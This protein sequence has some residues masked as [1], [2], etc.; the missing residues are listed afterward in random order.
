M[1][2][3]CTHNLNYHSVIAAIVTISDPYRAAAEASVG[4]DSLI[5][6]SDVFE[7]LQFIRDVR[8]KSMLRR[9]GCVLV[10]KI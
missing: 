8:C 5:M 9:T 2:L 10:L 6:T 7:F 3:H 4:E 1:T